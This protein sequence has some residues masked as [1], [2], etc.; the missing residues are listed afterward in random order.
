MIRLEAPGESVSTWAQPIY[1]IMNRK[2]LL[3]SLGAIATLL[4]A[5]AP[6]IPYQGQH[7]NA[8]GQNPQGGVVGSAEQQARDEARRQAALREKAN[9]P[10]PPKREV[11]PDTGTPKPGYPRAIP[12]PGKDGYVFNPYTNNPVDV[13]AIPSGT[14]VKDPQDPDGDKHFF[15][16]P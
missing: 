2:V 10:A 6:L 16:V 14:L 5:C 4:S 12:I 13:R 15:R 11:K 8:P 3:P 1:H 9:E 7:P